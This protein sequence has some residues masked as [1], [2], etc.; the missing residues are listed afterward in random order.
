MSEIDRLLA[1]H[2]PDG[3]EVMRLGEIGT[4]VRGRRFTKADMVEAGIPCIHYGEI[5]TEYGVSTRT[6]VSYV[7][8]DLHNH[9]RYAQPGDV[10]VAGV[11]ETVEDVGKAVAWLGEGE[12]AIHDDSF[13]F[14]SELDPTYV[15][16]YFQT[17]TF[18][19]EKEQHVSRAK[20]KRLSS[21]GLSRVTIPVP[22]PEVQ[23]E[24]VRILDKMAELQAGLQAELLARSRQY[25]HYRDQL[26]TFAETEEVRWAALSEVCTSVFSGGTPLATNRDFYDGDIPWLRTQEVNYADIYDTAVKITREGL[27]SSSAKWVRP[28]SVIV[29]ISGAGVTRGRVAVNR[30]SLTTNQHCCNLEVDESQAHFRYVYY[31]L[32]KHYDDL[33]S[34]GHGN[35]SDLNV[36]IIKRYPIALPTLDEQ[37]RIVQLLDKFNALVGLSVGLPAEI[38]ARRKQY[39]YYRDKLLTFQERVA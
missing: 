22:P 15:S 6:T 2:C 39:E 8:E 38:N 34:R 36:G 18:Q 16:Y 3:V 24:I 4:L 13:L 28:N 21:S 32:L 25:E 12:V 20:M 9:L 33:R 1:E 17:S 14:R 23:H 5:Y 11:G 27:E 29:A 19:A 37:E 7:R 10:I 31:W 26:L 35:R 30:I